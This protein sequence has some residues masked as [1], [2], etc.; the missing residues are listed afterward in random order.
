MKFKSKKPKS[1]TK[2]KTK[3]K[4]DTKSKSKTKTKTSKTKTKSQSKD[5]TKKPGKKFGKLTFGK[6]K[7]PEG[8]KSKTAESKTQS[9]ESVKN[10]KSK[11]PKKKRRWV[12]FILLALGA[13]VIL[14]T[15]IAIIMFFVLSGANEGSKKG[16]EAS[17]N[18]PI[19]E[20]VC[21]TQSCKQL[22]AKML[23]YM[24]DSVKP[25]D[26]FYKYTCGKYTIVKSELFEMAEDKEVELF[27]Y[28]EKYVPK[29]R[30][31][32]IAKVL[33]D[34][35]K[36]LKPG[37]EYKNLNV[38]SRSD[39]TDVLIEMAKL[40]PIHTRFF[41]NAV[42]SDELVD[43]KRVLRLVVLND[44]YP[45][46]VSQSAEHLYYAYRSVFIQ[47]VALQTEN[48]VTNNGDRNH[49]KLK[50]INLQKY[51]LGLLP[52]EIRASNPDFQV[53]YDKNAMLILDK[54]VDKLD[55]QQG[56]IKHLAAVYQ[57]DM[58]SVFY[59]AN[60]YD[61]PTT[62]MIEC[63]GVVRKMFPGTFG[64]IYIKQY[65][66]QGNVEI[67]DKLLEEI[68]DVFNEMIDENSW[69]D[70]GLKQA[71]K[72]ELKLLKGSI[73]TPDEHENSANIDRMY[74]RVERSKR[75]EDQ[76]CFELV[77]NIMAMNSEET[78]ARVFKKE[79]VTY[80]VNP[81]EASPNFN[82]ASHRTSFPAVLMNFPYIDKDLPEWNKVASIG[83][84][85]AHE[86]GHAFDAQRFPLTGALLNHQMNSGTRGEFEKRVK[87][88]VDKYSNYKFDNG[89]KSNGARTKDE[90]TA[91]KIGFDLS[92]RLFK[93]LRNY[94]R[95]PGFENVTIEQQYF[96]RMAMDWC[97]KMPLPT[98]VRDFYI[99]KDDH[100][101][102][103]FRVNGIMSNS[104]AFAK[105]YGCP[106][107]SKMNP[108]QKCPMF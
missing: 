49:I 71:L 37:E 9:K 55:G 92:Y 102:D 78:F 60:Y 57:S 47:N 17:K 63:Y 79:Q 62:K 44:L 8:T 28:F 21:T 29:T 50:N 88:I 59:H 41:H 87:C 20:E 32:R 80:A 3:T 105:A 97:R 83:F 106:V 11:D 73:G 40:F 81:M 75:A 108:T 42:V 27:K 7:K 6:H 52:E 24:D 76:S 36:L 51:F 107:N 68:K 33:F 85:M 26:D 84:L 95:L 25:C 46:A 98:E 89:V 15:I 90:D 86:V 69:I 67:A 5:S 31:E 94:Q 13:F 65:V 66:K 100:T 16:D 35:C 23:K 48:L 54:V 38:W 2:T 1:N 101:A 93:K 104:E 4:T 34:K 39:L 61:T 77:R 72:K 19:I 82:G 74:S 30:S 18:E 53:T 43:G 58:R 10:R 70:S 99:N 103:M 22:S 56:T 96:Q 45:T 12:K 64:M 91:D 14:A